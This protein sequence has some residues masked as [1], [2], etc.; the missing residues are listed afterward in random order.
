MESR[1]I[2]WKPICQIL[3]EKF[4]SLK[5][6]KS[7]YGDYSLLLSKRNIF[8]QASTLFMNSKKRSIYLKYEDINR[9][10]NLD[11][12]N[13][14]LKFSEEFA[15]S[16]LSN[17]ASYEEIYA[18]SSKIFE[19]LFKNLGMSKKEVFEVNIGNLIELELWSY[20]PFSLSNDWIVNPISLYYSLKNSDDPRI[21]M[22]LDELLKKR[23]IIYFIKHLLILFMRVGT[24]RIRW[25]KRE[26]YIDLRQTIKT[27]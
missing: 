13:N 11:K 6:I 7:K 1:G 4:D 21:E 12:T 10:N 19:K 17:L 22:E 16:K 26:N 14:T 27:I 25:M 3:Q 24:R 18:I 15:L 8:E 5:W 9:L 20:S 23:K 2:Y